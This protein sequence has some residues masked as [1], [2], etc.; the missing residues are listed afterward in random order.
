MLRGERG[1]P[2]G[3]IAVVSALCVLHSARL[4]ALFRT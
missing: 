2:A 4:E 3:E 1:D